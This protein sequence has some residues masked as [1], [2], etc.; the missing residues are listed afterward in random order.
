MKYN[1]LEYNSAIFLSSIS[2]FLG[3][4]INRV[5]SI[6]KNDS[7]ISVIIGSILGLLFL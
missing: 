6:A 3:I 7:W 4:G 1:K 2:L 5:V